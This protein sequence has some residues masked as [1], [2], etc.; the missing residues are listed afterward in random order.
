M[1]RLNHPPQS[2]AEKWAAL[3]EAA[4]IGIYCGAAAA[5]ILILVALGFVCLRQRRKGRLEHAL[6]DAR[7]N[8]ER[9][10]MENYQSD[11]KQTEWKSNGYYQVHG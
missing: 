9:N 10:E 7:Y 6:D 2:L 1:Q 8:N 4:H 3:P 11:W 5:G